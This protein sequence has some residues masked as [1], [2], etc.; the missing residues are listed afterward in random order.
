MYYQSR[1]FL[2]NK[3]QVILEKQENCCS[4]C[5]STILKDSLNHV[6]E[7]NIQSVLQ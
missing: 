6:E 4:E 2:K 5:I 7:K 3:Y 1:G